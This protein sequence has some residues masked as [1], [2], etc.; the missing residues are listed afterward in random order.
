[1]GG[2]VTH[3]L[4]HPKIEKTVFFKTS[5]LFTLMIINENTQLDKV[6]S[7]PKGFERYFYAEDEKPICESF[8]FRAPP[9]CF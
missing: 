8:F 5:P 7:P 4:E 1:M 2:G 3:V 6:V 9:L